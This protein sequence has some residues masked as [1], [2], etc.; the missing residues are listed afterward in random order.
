LRGTT[1]LVA[2]K[3]KGNRLGEKVCWIEGKDQGRQLAAQK[4]DEWTSKGE[5]RKDQIVV[6][7]ETCEKEEWTYC[8][9]DGDQT[10][11]EAL[12][13]HTGREDGNFVKNNGTQWECRQRMEGGYNQGPTEFTR[14]EQL[15]KKENRKAHRRQEKWGKKT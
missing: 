5:R 12:A 11:M 7:E 9:F 13:V 3:K 15:G 1:I 14:D 6:Y 10:V 4:G 2:G 8:T